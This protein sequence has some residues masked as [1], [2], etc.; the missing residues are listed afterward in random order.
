MAP[1][2]G[3]AEEFRQQ[4]TKCFD[5]I[6]GR[7]TAGDFRWVRLQLSDEFV[8]FRVEVR[9]HI[10]FHTTGKLSRF[11]REGFRI[12]GEFLVRGSFFR[13]AH[14]FASH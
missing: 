7:F 12:G 14:F 13:T 2:S 8:R 9:R 3:T 6:L 4:W 11:L 5:R 1:V 10:A